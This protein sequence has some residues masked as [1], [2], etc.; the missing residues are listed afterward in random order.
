MTQLPPTAASAQ[1]LAGKIVLL[2]GANTGIGRITARE[3]ARRGARLFLACRSEA[4]AAEVLAE[5]RALG[6]QA[7]WLPLDLGDLASVRRCAERFL[8]SGLPLHL[9]I[10]NA[11]L[12]GKRGLTTSGFELAFGT[13]HLG[14][15]LL[16]QLL[17]ERMKASG[18]ARI[19]NLASRAHY[20][21]P[22]ID[23]EALRRPTAT[24]T[25]I[26]EYS[27]S[28]LANVLFTAELARRL[29]GTQV[30]SYALHPGVIA[31]DIWRA[32]PWPFRWLVLLRTVP[33][34]RGYQT[35]LHCAASAEAGAESGLY[36]SEAQAQT[37]SRLARAPTL[38]AELW[39]RSEAWVA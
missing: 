14:H 23:W 20:R 15:F 39:R 22:G 9:L 25:G 36:Y 1:P 27:V 12:A 35:T 6:S 2:T 32:V 31:S 8:A 11:G 29:E 10:N 33:L 4:R 16:T 19:V 5:V 21:A 3:L 24:L 18:P 26:R 13:N 37:P 28:K 7:E 38:A 30:H 34:E 17:L